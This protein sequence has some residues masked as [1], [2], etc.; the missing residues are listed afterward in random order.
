M[1]MGMCPCTKCVQCEQK[2]EEGTE[3]PE[4]RVK[5]L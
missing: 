1:C 2:P 3:S 4:T 5:I